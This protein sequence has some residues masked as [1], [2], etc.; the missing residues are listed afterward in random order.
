MTCYQELLKFLN[1][2]SYITQLAKKELYY[3]SNV[4]TSEAF[5]LTQS[6]REKVRIVDRQVQT[7]PDPRHNSHSFT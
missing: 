6:F 4:K 2:Y 3:Y 7:P 5:K 1:K